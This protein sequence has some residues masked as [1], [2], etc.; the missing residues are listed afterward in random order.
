LKGHEAWWVNFD[1]SVGGEIKK[2]R[3]YV[4]VI[5]DASSRFRNRAQVVPL[6]SNVGRLYPSEAAVVFEGQEEASFG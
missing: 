4:I 3:P 5:N 1:L 6:T 2:R